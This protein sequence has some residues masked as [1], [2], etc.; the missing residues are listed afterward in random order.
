MSSEQICSLGEDALV[1]QIRTCLGDRSPPAP[2]GIGD[3]CAAVPVHAHDDRILLT[4][5]SLTWKIHFDD[6]ATAAEAG[7]KLLKRNLSDI[8][9]MAGRPRYALL[10]LQSGPDLRTAWLLDFVGGLAD[11]AREWDVMVVGGDVSGLAHGTFS[12]SVTLVGGS[13]VPL[14]RSTARIGDLVWVTGTL[15]GSL[16][17]HHLHFTPR[18]KEAIFLAHHAVPTS[19]MDV[20]DGIG[21]DLPR[22]IPEGTAARID[23]TRLPLSPS[24]VGDPINVREKRALFDGEDYELVFTT[25]QGADSIWVKDFES[26]FPNVPITRIGEVIDL[27]PSAASLVWETGEPVSGTA[28]EHFA[29]SPTIPPS[30]REDG[31]ETPQA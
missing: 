1:R 5:D 19:M 26:T 17:G 31:P 25:A 21:S 8:A 2:E 7:A 10:N 28:F 15:G 24:T 14:T 6:T 9:A 16:S 12:A 20:S 30:S 23:R 18:L 4:I 11:C 13:V 3:D 22:L 27:P 29:A